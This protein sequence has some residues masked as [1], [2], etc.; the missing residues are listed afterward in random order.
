MTNVHLQLN[1][2]AVAGGLFLILTLIFAPKK[3]PG[4]ER[5]VAIALG[6][7]AEAWALVHTCTVEPHIAHWLGRRNVES[8]IFLAAYIGGIVIGLFLALAIQGVF[9]GRKCPK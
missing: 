8:L 5:W 4:K 9:F 3:F 2:L 6:C 7:F 1:L